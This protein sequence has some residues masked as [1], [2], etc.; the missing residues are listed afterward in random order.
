MIVSHF[1]LNQ[2]KNSLTQVQIN[3][4]NLPLETPKKKG[5][6]PDQVETFHISKQ[7]LED[8]GVDINKNSPNKTNVKKIIEKFRAKINERG[9]RGILGIGKLFKIADKDGNN[10]ID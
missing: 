8:P 10:N 5:P 3:S 2:G 9:T 7:N 1:Q 6:R 4:N